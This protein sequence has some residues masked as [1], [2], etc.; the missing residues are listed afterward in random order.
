MREGDVI[1]E[2]D[3]HAMA[4]K[5]V[6]RTVVSGMSGIARLYVRRG[7]KALFFGLRREAPVAAREKVL[8]V[9]A[10]SAGDAAP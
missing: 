1:L 8:T 10:G 5:V 7:S 2:I 4:D 3:G 6:Y 9:P